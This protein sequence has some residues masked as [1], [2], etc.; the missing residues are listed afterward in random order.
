MKLQLLPTILKKTV[1]SFRSIE[2]KIVLIGALVIFS[3]TFKLGAQTCTISN[4]SVSIPS[5]SVG[6]G[7]TDATISLGNSESN[8]I[9][10]L[11]NNTTNAIEDKQNGTGAS[12]N[13]DVSDLTS[14]SVYSIIGAYRDSGLSFDGVND[15]IYSSNQFNYNDGTWEAW[16]KKDNW[17]DHH[18][19]ILFG[20]GISTSVDGSF[21][22]SL[23]P[24][25][26]HFRYGGTSEGGNGYVLSNIT[27]SFTSG[28][29]HHLAVSWH[30]TGTETT[31]KL[32]VDGIEYG[33]SYVSL[34]LNGNSSQ[35]NIGGGGD[36]IDYFGPGTMNDARVWSF[37]KVETQV[38]ASMNNCLIG[39]ET[40]LLANWKL[41]E[42]TGSI[43]LDNSVG[44]NNGQ[45][46]NFTT[47]SCWTAG[48]IYCKCRQTMT[49]TATVAVKPKPSTPTFSGNSS[50]IRC[51]G[52]SA[53]LH[54][55]SGGPNYVWMLNGANSITEGCSGFPIGKSGGST[56]NTGSGSGSGSGSGRIAGSSTSIFNQGDYT[57]AALAVDSAYSF[58]LYSADSINGSRCLSDTSFSFCI[59]V[60]SECVTSAI[61]P[62]IRTT[63]QLYPNP[64]NGEVELSFEVAK[65]TDL[66]VTIYNQTGQVV[67][68]DNRQRI[69][70]QYL[71]KLD[72][73]TLLK[74]LYY[75]SI[76][77]EEGVVGKSLFIE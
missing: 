62:S 12:I 7:T 49:Q 72:L 47:P 26:F 40:N 50:I 64:S 45:L 42:G 10:L 6:C 59:L 58:T 34:L 61:A 11:K 27:Q 65:A 67:F 23:H 52:G 51:G 5:T 53:I 46:F 55:L 33:N 38:M 17:A 15:Y 29:W 28:S 60:A 70:G 14:T 2:S 73:H 16:V 18:N 43:A 57:T 44:N 9:Y 1:T 48:G 24:A 66:S 75:V 74:G 37:A 54:P 21:Y 41:N 22:V 36:Y 63:I 8:L 39:N 68:V 56:G 76:I 25:G 77:T 30:N 35:T 19:D 20:N 31:L 4:Q 13:F 3:N 32:F 69:N 71:S